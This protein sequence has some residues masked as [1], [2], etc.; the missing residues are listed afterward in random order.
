MRKPV[1]LLDCLLAELGTLEGDKRVSTGRE[2]GINR[3]LGREHLA[4]LFE[5]LIE[6]SVRPVFRTIFHEDRKWLLLF[7]LGFLRDG[8]AG[9]VI[10]R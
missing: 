7:V 3:H 9:L 10:E 1:G 6:V 8:A 5:V 2:I 4:I